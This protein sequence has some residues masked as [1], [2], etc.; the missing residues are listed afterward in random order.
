MAKEDV[1]PLPEQVPAKRR[2]IESLLDVHIAMWLD[3]DTLSYGD[4]KRLDAEKRRRKHANRERSIGLIIAPEGVTPEQKKRVEFL[5]RQ[6]GATVIHHHMLSPSLHHICGQVGE[7]HQ[8]QVGKYGDRV[9]DV[10]QAADSFI[11]A[12]R[13]MREPVK[14]VD[15]SVWWGIKYAKHRRRSVLVVLPNGTVTT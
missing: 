13:E 9:R 10:V 2:Q 12:P 15:G 3:S 14:K 6:S 1:P 5:L 8:H 11:A 4:R 7:V